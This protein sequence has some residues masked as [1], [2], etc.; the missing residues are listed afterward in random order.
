MA[1]TY[2]RSDQASIG[3]E[4]SGVTLDHES[5]DVL[6]GGEAT[7]EG[8]QL[9]PGGMAPMIA[10]GGIPKRSP[11]TVKRLWSEALIKIFGQLDGVSGTAAVTV[12]YTVLNSRVSATPHVITYTGVLGSVS[13]PNYEASKAEAAFLMITVEA[14]G[15]VQA[16]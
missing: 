5:W 15:A 14:D 11:L 12:K 2:Y 16:Q 13:R 4:V 1:E 7:V 10:K 8:V 6:E 3:V 9:L